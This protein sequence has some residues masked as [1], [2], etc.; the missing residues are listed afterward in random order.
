MLIVF[1][2]VWHMEYVMERKPSEY[3]K[4]YSNKLVAVCDEIKKEIEELHIEEREKKK[5]I[6]ILKS[7]EDNSIDLL[8][9]M[10]VN[11]KDNEKIASLHKEILD[12]RERVEKLEADL[13]AAEKECNEFKYNIELVK[14]LEDM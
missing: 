4:E 14:Q 10:N 12:I 9:P 13:S 2:I 6:D 3:F 11:E 5:F 7:G 1:I 8:N